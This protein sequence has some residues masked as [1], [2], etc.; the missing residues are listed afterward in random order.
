MI[1]SQT[2]KPYIKPNSTLIVGFSGGPDSVCLLILLSELKQELNLTIIAAHLDHQ[3]RQESAKDSAWCKRFCDNLDITCIVKTPAD[4]KISIKYNGSKEE[5]GRKLRRS[6]FQELA[7]QY[8]ADHILLAHHADDQLETFFIRL[9]R[10]S[11]L[12]GLTGMQQQDG[13]YLRPLLQTTKEEILNYLDNENIAYLIDSTNVDPKYLRNRIRHNLMPQLMQIDGRFTANLTSCINR[14]QKTDDFLKLLSEQTWQN[15]C[16]DQNINIVNLNDF[17]KLHEIIQHR[18]LL[19]MMIKQN[20]SFCPSSSL[21]EE[22][23]RFLKKSDKKSHQLTSTCTIIK[24]DG[25]FS[26]KSL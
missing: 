22:I 12:T 26:F 16:K 4:L 14:L 8:K 13:L 18:I 6:F 3:W 25:Y 24:Q 19:A 20:S 15:I 23:M 21:F 11:C 10:G 9:I 7:T 5:L 1:C 2:I 17:L